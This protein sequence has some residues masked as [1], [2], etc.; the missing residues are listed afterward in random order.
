MLGD[1]EGELNEKKRH[2][3]KGSERGARK[4][5]V[6]ELAVKEEVV[7]I[8]IGRKRDDNRRVA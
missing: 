7:E 4:K 5:R 1:R 2:E 6:K 8:N 3:G